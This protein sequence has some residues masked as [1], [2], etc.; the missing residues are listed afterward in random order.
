MNNKNKSWLAPLV[1][2]A[3]VTVAQPAAAA[4]SVS[5]QGWTF[6]HDVSGSYDGLSLSNVTYQGHTLIEK[7]SLPVMRV[8][9]ENNDCGPYADRL[10]GS[11]SVIPWANNTKLLQREFTLNGEQ[12]Y[13]IG[14][15]DQIGSY[16][17]YQ[18]YYLSA[19]GTIDAH[20]YSKGLQCVTDH[21]HYPNWRIDFDIDGAGADQVLGDRGIGFELLSQE[22]DGRATAAVNHAWRVRDATTGAYVDVLPG[23]PDFSIPDGNTTVPVTAYDQHSV[24]GRLYRSSEDTGWT[25]G[26]NTQVPYNNLENISAADTVLWY[27][28]FLPHEADE[29]ES[30]WHS[31]GV[32]LVAHIGASS[33][34]VP[35][36]PPGGTAF[37]GGAITIRDNQVAAPYPSTI[38]V[39]GLAGTIEKVTVRLDGLTH[40][41][42]DDID[43]L[44]VGPG[45]QAVMLMSDAGGGANVS[46][47]PLTFDSAAFA[48][49]LENTKIAGGIVQPADYDPGETL[50][51][52]APAG[53]Y[54]TDLAVFNGLS[55]NGTWSL[56][57]DDD[58][59]T[60]SGSIGGWT[61]TITTVAPPPDAD[62]DG[63][64]DALDNCTNAPNGPLIPDVGG[65]SQ[66]DT[67][68]DG[69]GNLCDGDFDNNGF[70]NYVDLAYF[71]N[72]FGSEDADADLDG[73]GGMV[74]FVDLAI[75]RSLF[76]NPPGPAAP[77]P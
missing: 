49:V 2:A 57:V 53:P 6:D 11:L 67:D 3:L 76:G 4:G 25:Y 38:A 23:F 27:E 8:F 66:R 36:P 34:P 77:P 55:A 65:A 44:L 20:I 52:P 50:P 64:E 9:Y 18:A 22:F 74:N 33:A 68:G 54:G 28:A 40:T 73:S 15:R 17:I 59:N 56:F 70:V 19:G 58:E 60:D 24:F 47:M 75:F 45:G 12:W 37:T 63:V 41:Y 32:R 29:G 35:T 48:T 39:A 14:I 72:A 7:L 51:A 16:D 42:P 13:E 61:L 21:V 1:A 62:S 69:Y 30:L 71:R 5:W 43:L 10:G 46:N 31:T 26:P